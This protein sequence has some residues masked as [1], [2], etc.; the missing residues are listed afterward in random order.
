L[1]KGIATYNDADRAAA[2]NTLSSG[3]S[4]AL[5][6]LQALEDKTLDRNFVTAYHIRLMLN[7]ANAD[8]TARVEK[9]W[10]K[11][12]E[13]PAETKA[14]IAHVKKMFSDAPLWAY[15]QLGGKKVFEKNCQNCHSLNGV[16]GKVGPDLA[17]SW[18]NGLDYFLDN[19][20]DPNAVV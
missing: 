7:L 15:D 6:M 8:V 18:R 9:L 1:L 4:L 10:G 16:G 2:L 19:I 11:I 14:S 12:T 20:I 5:P 17:G 13:T 3:P